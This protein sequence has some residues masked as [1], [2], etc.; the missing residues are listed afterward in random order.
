L[1]TSLIGS[2][3]VFDSAMVIATPA[4][5]PGGASR[6]IYWYITSLAFNQFK[7]GYA[8]TVAVA[9]FVVSMLIAWIQL[10]WLRADT[11]EIN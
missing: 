2:F 9:L 3:Q 5:G 1:V 10:R 11:S 4:G 7:L 6:V 8:A